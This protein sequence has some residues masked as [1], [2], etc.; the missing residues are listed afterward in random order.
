MRKPYI[1]AAVLAVLATATPASGFASAGATTSCGYQQAC[2]AY[3]QSV[4]RIGTG[5]D[6]KVSC[7]AH[8]PYDVQ[9]TGVQCYILGNSGDKHFTPTR[10]LEGETSTL[11]HTFGAWQL[12]SNT[13]RVC[14]GGGYIDTWGLV[15]N[16][17]NFSCGE[18]I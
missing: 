11:E 3:A 16:P 10:W 13:Y 8:T 5:T 17:T 18:V 2:A 6:V 7:S 9:T 4:P 15:H 14:T 1:R 12:R